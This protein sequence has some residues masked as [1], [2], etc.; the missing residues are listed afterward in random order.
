MSSI[1]NKKLIFSPCVLT[2]TSVHLLLFGCMKKSPATNPSSL[3]ESAQSNRGAAIAPQSNSNQGSSN[4][5]PAPLGQSTPPSPTTPAS[6]A[7]PSYAIQNPSIQYSI[8]NLI[9]AP[10][11]SSST[12]S[13]AT[14]QSYEIDYKEKAAEMGCV[15][16]SNQVIERL[17]YCVINSNGTSMNVDP[18]QCKNPAPSKYRKIF[19]PQL[20]GNYIGPFG[21]REVSVG[22]FK[23][24]A[25]SGTRCGGDGTAESPYLICTPNDFVSFMVDASGIH[26]LLRFRGLH[27]NHY[28]LAADIDLSKAVLPKSQGTPSGLDSFFF[29]LPNG[30]FDG[31]GHKIILGA[32]QTGL[33]AW[34]GFFL[35]ESTLRNLTVANPMT[36][37]NGAL[38]MSTQATD[39]IENC[40]V[41]NGTVRVRHYEYGG[42][43]LTYL[44]GSLS[45]SSFQGRIEIIDPVG[46]PSGANPTSVGGLVGMVLRDPNN[47]SG[48]GG[49]IT[50]SSAT[51]AIEEISSTVS[52]IAAGGIAGFSGTAARVSDNRVSG[53]FRLKSPHSYAGGILGNSFHG[54]LN[55]ESAL[56]AY[57]QSISDL[58]YSRGDIRTGVAPK[59]AAILRDNTVSNVTFF[60]TG[61]YSPTLGGCGNQYAWGESTSLNCHARY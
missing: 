16:E 13:T 8:P 14:W 12:A 21:M 1:K 48:L 15:D 45:N 44:A 55:S 9:S 2:L 31:N 6:P 49:K 36:T 28:K 29:S 17:S 43:L 19:N 46:E 30:T 24:D 56:A 34:K 41:I 39:V 59:Y 40:H 61:R 51:F 58:E 53:T 50:G 26:G 47:A 5:N 37:G 60:G 38:G 11:S 32:N 57:I 22:V 23:F 54:Y 52:T 27:S 3:T 10:Q 18:N 20:C 42:G 35:S 33:R 25:A 7:Q 4:P